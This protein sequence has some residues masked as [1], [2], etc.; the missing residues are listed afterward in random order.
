MVT[1]FPYGYRKPCMD[2]QYSTTH[3]HVL[4]LAETHP[5]RKL[6]LEQLPACLTFT[7]LDGQKSVL[8][9]KL[10]HEVHSPFGLQHAHEMHQ[11]HASWKSTGRIPYKR[12]ILAVLAE[13]LYTTKIK[14][15]NLKV[16]KCGLRSTTAYLPLK[17]KP[18]RFIL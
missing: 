4:T 15:T 1:I 3:F 12:E 13:G 9:R 6:T 10:L 18:P 16:W 7:V 17:Q 11:G 8:W 5:Q 2:F 14:T